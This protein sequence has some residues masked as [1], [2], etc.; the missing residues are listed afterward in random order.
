MN[1]FLAIVSIAVSV[2][3]A[4]V[5]AMSV[6]N[7]LHP[8]SVQN[9]TEVLDN[10]LLAARYLAKSNNGATLVIAPDANNGGTDVWLYPGR[11]SSGA[12]GTDRRDAPTVE[13]PLTWNGLMNF[14]ILIAPNGQAAATSFTMGATVSTQ[15]ACTS[16]I[17]VTIGTAG[18]NTATW[19]IPC[20]EGRA[21]YQ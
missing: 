3:F 7:G 18:G 16:T 12:F 14:A 11:P 21:V 20:T 8:R 15:P 4:G 9:A 1:P 5:L 2:L 13:L 19:S 6:S 10:E 17:D